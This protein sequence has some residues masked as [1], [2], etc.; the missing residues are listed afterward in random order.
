MDWVWWMENAAMAVV[1]MIGKGA[2]L[3]CVASEKVE[4]LISRK[5][6]SLFGHVVSI[7]VALGDLCQRSR[8]VVAL[9]QNVRGAR[10]RPVCS[11]SFRR[12][13]SGKVDSEQANTLSSR[14]ITNSYHLIVAKLAY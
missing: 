6:K 12:F 5:D 7:I 4:T 9:V 11:K 8:V 10:N 1:S 13:C 3:L 2:V 14:T